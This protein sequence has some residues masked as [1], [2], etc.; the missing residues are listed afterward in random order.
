MHGICVLRLDLLPEKLRHS[1]V[2]WHWNRRSFEKREVRGICFHGLDFGSVVFT[3]L[4]GE[5]SFN[6]L[7]TRATVYVLD[8]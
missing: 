6:M 2:T 5:R 7:S 1:L 4:H 8:D 3:K